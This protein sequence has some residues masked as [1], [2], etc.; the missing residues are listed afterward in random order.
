MQ[1]HQVDC[2]SVQRLPFVSPSL[3]AMRM[4][5]RPGSSSEYSNLWWTPLLCRC[6]LLGSCAR[7]W[8][9]R[10]RIIISQRKRPR[11]PIL[12]IHWVHFITVWI[13]SS[14]ML[15][16][17]KMSWSE[18]DGHWVMGWVVAR[19]SVKGR[20]GNCL[21]WRWRIIR[22]W[23]ARLLLLSY[24]HSLFGG[25]CSICS[26]RRIFGEL[27]THSF[28]RYSSCNLCA[29]FFLPMSSFLLLCIF[30]ILCLLSCN[31][32]NDVTWCARSCTVTPFLEPKK[33]L[34]Q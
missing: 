28:R 9:F 19:K 4:R 6:R 5:L 33:Y 20:I 13:F 34:M 22:L 15:M 10:C 1:T 2:I 3:S 32:F 25:F 26:A 31:F 14:C 11:Y 17:L 27:K 24:K 16:S 12:C 23:C 8:C 21:H 30:S 29:H 18:R 7:P